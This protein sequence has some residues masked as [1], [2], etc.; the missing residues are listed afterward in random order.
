MKNVCSSG[1]CSVTAQI[2]QSLIHLH[3][4]VLTLIILAGGQLLSQ[5]LQLDPLLVSLLDTLQSSLLTGG[6]LPGKIVDIYVIL[7]RNLSVNQSDI[8][9]VLCQPIRR[10]Y[11]PIS[12]HCQQSRLA[13]T[14]LSDQTISVA[15]AQ[16]QLGVL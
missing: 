9:I 7:Y 6:H 4:V 12:Q 1:L 8:S 14:I 3:Q 2:I 13:T 5:L 11:L 10:E 16:L 15:S